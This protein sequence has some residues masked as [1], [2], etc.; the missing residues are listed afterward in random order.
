MAAID[1][2][3]QLEDLA[4]YQLALLQTYPITSIDSLLA[5]IRSDNT[6]IP[7]R[8]AACHA[9]SVLY[10]KQ[11]F[12]DGRRL[13]PALLCALGARSITVRQETLWTLK[14]FKS[15]RVDS[16][17]LAILLN[18]A[19]DPVLRWRIAA[20]SDRLM[21]QPN[22][23]PLLR[24]IIFD[25]A[26]PLHLRSVVLENVSSLSIN[27]SIALL[28]HPLPDMRF[29]VAYRLSQQDWE[30]AE[31]ITPAFALLDQVAA[32]D[33]VLPHYWGWHVD[34]E[35]LNPLGRIRFER[36]RHWIRDDDGEA[37]EIPWWQTWIISPAPEYEHVTARY[38]QFQ[39]DGSCRNL[40]LP[41]VSL[42]IEVDTLRSHLKERWPT[43]TI[44][45][46]HLECRTYTLNWVLQHDQDTL[47]GGL[48]RDGSTVV[49]TGPDTIVF[50]MALWLA[51]VF[52]AEPLYLYE[53]AGSGVILDP[54]GS[55]NDL[56]AQLAGSTCRI[57]EEL[58]NQV[59]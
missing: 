55:V 7:L 20:L 41:P 27:D 45:P 19:E 47:I 18:P 24:R 26:E 17:L 38:R 22:H 50:P 3:A 9:V 57:K 10:S 58:R 33:H 5:L 1:I 39:A 8:T 52:P 28:E 13:I 29:W 53:W 31:S 14:R 44:N 49:L 34:R 43:V 54:H 36:Y 2:I 35:A 59:D 21:D 12:T 37:H 16:A 56:E 32:A 46:A 23:Q 42:Q 25:E 48:H 15:K 51:S 30:S 40:P 4:P 11:V 6:D